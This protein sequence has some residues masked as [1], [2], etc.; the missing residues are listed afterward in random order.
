MPGNPN[1][2]SH[3]SHPDPS[4]HPSA[5]SSL[6]AAAGEREEF[7]VSEGASAGATKAMKCGKKVAARREL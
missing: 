1:L 2:F 7:G 6:H 4:S 5:L 3:L